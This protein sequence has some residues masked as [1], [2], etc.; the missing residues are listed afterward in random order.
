MSYGDLMGSENAQ[1][2]MMINVD[3]VS[4]IG[5]AEAN[6]H[7]NMPQQ[8]IAFVPDPCFSSSHA[9]LKYNQKQKNQPS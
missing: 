8:S 6:Y 4:D 7:Q 2:M 5:G 9:Y 3:D 1:Q